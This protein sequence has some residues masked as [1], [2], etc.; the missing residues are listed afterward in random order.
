MRETDV[1][2]VN[3]KSKV[4]RNWGAEMGEQRAQTR[5][6]H[7]RDPRGGASLLVMTTSFWTWLAGLYRY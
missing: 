7:N 2:G 5:G 3:L 4:I 1:L 6:R